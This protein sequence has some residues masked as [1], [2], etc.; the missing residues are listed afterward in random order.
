MK[1]YLYG[2]VIAAAVLLGGLWAANYLIDAKAEAQQ[3]ASDLD[4]CRAIANRIGTLKASGASVAGGGLD[5]AVLQRRGEEALQSIGL[6]ANHL[7][8][9]AP[10]LPRT[11]GQTAYKEVPTNLILRDMTL[12]QVVG[13]LLAITGDGSPLQTRALRFSG[14]HDA[15]G[16]DVQWTAELTLAYLVYQP[17]T[18]TNLISNE[19]DE[20]R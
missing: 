12:R 17:A 15:G 13:F 4:A 9:V 18:V 3:A 16:G 2:A 7:V 6:P 14:A 19:K 10:D 20:G 1:A 11:V 8:Q 5:Q